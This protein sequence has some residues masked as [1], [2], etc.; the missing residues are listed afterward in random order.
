[1]LRTSAASRSAL[2]SLVVEG[3]GALRPVV[4]V[5]LEALHR[6]LA[7][8]GARVGVLAWRRRASVSLPLRAALQQLR[9]TAA[10]T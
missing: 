6:E 2:D 5:V 1:M 10:M 7:G 3:L 4:R 8:L 9:S